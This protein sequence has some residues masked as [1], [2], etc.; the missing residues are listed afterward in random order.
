MKN[1]FYKKGFISIEHMFEKYKM[2]SEKYFVFLFLL[3]KYRLSISITLSNTFV[4]HKLKG[5]LKYKGKKLDISFTVK[6]SLK[7]PRDNPLTT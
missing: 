7:M 3:I 1:S 6:D 5:D 2:R 4:K